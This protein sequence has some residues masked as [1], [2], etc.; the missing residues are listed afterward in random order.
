MKIGVFAGFLIITMGA[1]AAVAMPHCGS[2]DDVVSTL[3][4]QFDETHRASG[5]ESATGLM[6]IWASDID[7]SWTILLTRPD[8]QTCVMATGSYWLEAI[9]T[10]TPEGAPA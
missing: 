7:G 1:Q 9:E 3:V 4:D 6:E 5:L 10:A 8:G 2:R